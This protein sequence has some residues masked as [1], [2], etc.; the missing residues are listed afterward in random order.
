MGLESWRIAGLRR[1]R[2]RWLISLTILS[3]VAAGLMAGCGSST[4]GATEIRFEWRSGEGF[5]GQVTVYAAPAN[6]MSGK[7]D[8]YG[9]GE[10]PDF[11]KELPDGRIHGEI[12]SLVQVLL[13]VRNPTDEPLPFWAAPHLPMPRNSE[14]GLLIQCLCTGQQ[15]EIAPHGTWTKVIAAGL[16]PEAKTRGPVVLTHVLVEGTV[17][18]T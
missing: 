17:P 4:S 15:Y 16:N 12:G 18:V 9:E 14:A 1:L 3:V 13:V 6:A 11:G 2:V 5:P 8:N 7:I 10:A